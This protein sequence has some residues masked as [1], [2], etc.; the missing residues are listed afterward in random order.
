M[1]LIKY[2]NA[3]RA[4]AAARSTDEVKKI[5][6]ISIAMAAYA[7][8]AKNRDLE[9]D[10]FEIRLRSERRLG[11][12][13]QAQP[14]A[15]GAIERGTKR[16]TTRDILKPAWLAEAGI[17][18]NLADR[19]RKLAALPA[20]QLK[21][22]IADGRD[23]VRRS[24]ERAILAKVNREERH[25]R[26]FASAKK[27][28]DP[29][30]LGPFPLI[31]ADPPWRWDHFGN[32]GAVNEAGKAATADQ[33]YPTLSYEQIKSF[34][35]AG[36][37]IS[38]IAHR[39]AALFLWCTAANIP[40]ALEVITAWGFEFRASAVWVKDR[41][42]RGLVFRNQHEPLLYAVRGNMPGPCEQPL[43]V[44]SFVRSAHSAKPPEVRQ[45]IES[46]YP[47][48]DQT[49]RL[50]LF[51]RGNVAGWSCAGFEAVSQAA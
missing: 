40:Q 29:E 2:D 51:A 10:A 1:K 45:A 26:I 24:A 39:D 25:E 5:R 37:P 48:F 33:H 30:N 13:M 44:F 31:Y 43:S 21:N 27:A 41:A 8:Q 11:E 38:E 7:R 34:K 36:K 22:L 3:C 18:K 50:E 42:G 23:D 14:K 4:L 6:N 28:A 32:A 35:V 15:R 49:S 16:G 17:D 20:E 19:A 47:Q 46:M 12:M 9:A